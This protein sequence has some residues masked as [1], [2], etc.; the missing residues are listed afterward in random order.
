MGWRWYVI[1]IEVLV[2]L[3]IITAAGYLLY[4]AKNI[5]SDSSEKL[6]T[7]T[8]AISAE[9]VPATD[10]IVSV[11]G[12][13]VDSRPIHT[14]SFGNGDKEILFI[15]GI[16]GGYEWNSVLLAY[17][18]IDYFTT[19]PEDIP[20]DISLVIIPVLNP[21]GLATVTGTTGRFTVSDVTNWSADGRGRFNANTVDLNR[22]FDCNW[23]PSSTWRSAPVQ[24]GTAAF[25][26]PEAQALRDYVLAAQPVATVFWHS[27]AN[28]V[29]ASECNAGVLPVTLDIM[30]AYA[31]AG[32]YAAVPV[33]DAYPIT[34]DAEGWLASIN[35]PAITVELESRDS[36]E[37]SRNLAGTK[38]VIDYF[39]E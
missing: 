19:T 3:L 38:S 11:I 1:I 7:S 26:E 13:S 27:V 32:S 21:D 12:Q 18:M 29:Y 37:W 10:P 28:A 25:S 6:A 34:G 31:T 15:G 22:N 2:G 24:T 30:D 23:S 39:S 20:A 33:F 5:T 9:A 36:I 8:A 14:Y 16:H 17:E 35:I 4:D